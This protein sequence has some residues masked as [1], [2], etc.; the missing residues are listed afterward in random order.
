[1][2]ISSCLLVIVLVAV[3]GVALAEDAAQT[4][5]PSASVAPAALDSLVV[6]LSSSDWQVREA[7][8][9]SIVALGD[10]ALKP[11]QQLA[12]TS[13]DP[14]MRERAQA[15]VRGLELARSMKPTRVSL[16]FKQAAAKDVYDALSAQGGAPWIVDAGGLL[17]PQASN[18]VTTD[19]DNIP[20]W[21]A[22]NQLADQTDLIADARNSE[23][24]LGPVHHP[25]GRRDPIS[26]S[27]PYMVTAYREAV[28]GNIRQLTVLVDP[29][30]TLLSCATEFRVDEVIPAGGR[31]AWVID[32][33]PTLMRQLQRSETN[34]IAVQ[35]IFP[36][37]L[38]Y[39]RGTVQALI[40]TRV[41]TLELNQIAQVKHV[42]KKLGTRKVV[43]D[44]NTAKPDQWT[45]HV[46]ATNTDPPTPG[47][48]EM[49]IKVFDAAGNRIRPGGGQGGGYGPDGI[50]WDV[51]LVP[52]PNA[53]PADKLVLVF[54][55]ETQEVQIPF[56]F[57]FP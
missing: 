48:V 10:A 1:M 57:K 3:A 21:E 11:M 17:N 29:R 19:L 51:G 50:A 42:E 43:V 30:V 2:R 27:G 35:I 47:A 45:V 37:P 5:A 23:M 24:V 55:L 15:V 18:P 41:Q 32:Q 36:L 44:V 40:A 28:T 14:E 12:A 49:R 16:H 34:G 13:T 6:Q 46:T 56:E 9:T 39:L 4:S 53:G 33:N 25:G 20:F 38:S 31:P 52:Q 7:A 26:I 8:K 22:V 54:P